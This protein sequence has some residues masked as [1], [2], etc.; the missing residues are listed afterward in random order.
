[1]GHLESVYV[2]SFKTIAHLIVQ[3]QSFQ[4]SELYQ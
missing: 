2:T 3:D 4:E 1:M